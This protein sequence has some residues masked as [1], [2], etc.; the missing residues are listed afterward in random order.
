M[1]VSVSKIKSNTVLQVTYSAEYLAHN[2]HKIY[3]LYGYDYNCWW[4]LEHHPLS[5][6]SQRSRLEVHESTLWLVISEHRINDQTFQCLAC[7]KNT[8]S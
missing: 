2:G 5:A 1:I 6:A 4:C 7:N 3:I 8:W